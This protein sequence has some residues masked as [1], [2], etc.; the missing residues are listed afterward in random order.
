M[1]QFDQSNFAIISHSLGSRISLDALQESMRLTRQSDQ[2]MRT[3]VEKFKNK[4]MYIYMLSNQLPLLQT[5]AGITGSARPGEVFLYGQKVIN[6][7]SGFLK[8]CRS[9]LLA[10][11]MTSSAIPLVRIMPAAILT[12]DY[13]RSLPTLLFR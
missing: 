2:A 9:W 8:N 4:P 3:L 7:M 10:I 5:R 12:P 11:Q 1:S 6:M 13:A